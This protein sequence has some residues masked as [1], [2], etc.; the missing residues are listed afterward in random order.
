MKK[1]L[2]LSLI[3]VVLSGVLGLGSNTVVPVSKLPGEFGWGWG[4]FWQN[5]GGFFSDTTRYKNALLRAE[6]VNVLVES[7]S[8]DKDAFGDGLSEYEMSVLRIS[9]PTLR[10]TAELLGNESVLL[11]NKDLSI[12]S[13]GLGQAQVVEGLHAVFVNN[14]YDLNNIRAKVRVQSGSV[15]S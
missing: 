10:A 6:E 8:Q 12:L 14:V 1:F 4:V 2:L 9:D 15:L 7:E 3:L 11:G 13:S 5:F